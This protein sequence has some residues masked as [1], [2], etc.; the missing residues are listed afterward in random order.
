[1][2]LEMTRSGRHKRLVFQ[3]GV[4]PA[5]FAVKRTVIRRFPGWETVSQSRREGRSEGIAVAEEGQ[6]IYFSHGQSSH[7][8][9]GM[10][11]QKNTP[12]SVYPTELCM[13]SDMQERLFCTCCASG[14]RIPGVLTSFLWRRISVWLT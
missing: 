5:L 3:L 14:T 8:S 6:N 9:L 13:C 10:H 4:P 7:F 12:G 11:P 1:M 2:R